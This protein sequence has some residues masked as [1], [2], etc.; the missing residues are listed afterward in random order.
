MLKL[1]I[2]CAVLALIIALCS[3]TL[4][5]VVKINLVAAVICIAAMV[6]LIVELMGGGSQT[7]EDS[8]RAQ[9]PAMQ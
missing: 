5:V 8:Q 4:F 3:A 6:A 7:R 9:G 1:K 2:A